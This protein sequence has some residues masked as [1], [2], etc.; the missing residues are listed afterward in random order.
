MAGDRACWRGYPQSGLSMDTGSLVPNLVLPPREAVLPIQP[1]LLTI[2]PLSG[3]GQD[4]RQIGLQGAPRG[5]VTY[6]S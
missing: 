2:K 4:P 5:K 1:L 3:Q 6:L